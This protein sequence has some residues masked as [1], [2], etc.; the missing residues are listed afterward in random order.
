MF[1][2][3]MGYT[4]KRNDWIIYLL[5][6]QFIFSPVYAKQLLTLWYVSVLMGY[7][8]LFIFLFVRISSGRL[9]FLAAF[10]VFF[11]MF[12]I[13][14]VT[15]LIDGR[16]LEYLFV[17]TAGV[18]FSRNEKL[19]QWFSSIHFGVSLA[20][21]A[22]GLFIFWFVRA[23][24]YEYMSW[25]YFLAV[26]IFIVSWMLLGLKI[27]RNGISSGVSLW[28][29]W[30]VISYASFF[31][32]LYHRPIWRLITNFEGGLLNLDAAWIKLLPGSIIALVICYYLQR[33][34][35]LLTRRLNLVS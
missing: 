27:F 2:F 4:L 9:L 6:L 1:V 23:G 25:Q 16:F 31:T 35:D 19:Y 28:G 13:N 14:K 33:A 34:Y 8:V 30:S 18:Y 21:A 26:D 10:A 24:N 5:N 3:I 17:F 29:I 22:L 11:V 15:G 12:L 20:F 32:Y 7:Y